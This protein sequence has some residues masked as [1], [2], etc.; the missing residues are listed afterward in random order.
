[1]E[2]IIADFKLLFEYG[3]FCDKRML[4]A[5]PRSNS[6]GLKTVK[7]PGAVFKCNATNGTNSCQD[8]VLFD[9]RGNSAYE[10]KDNQWFGVSLKSHGKSVLAC[11]HRAMYYTTASN[12]HLLEGRCRSMNKDLLS[13]GNNFKPCRSNI[14]KVLDQVPSY[15]NYGQCQSGIGIDIVEGSQT[16]FL[17][18][19]VGVKNFIGAVFQQDS[20]E[21]NPMIESEKIQAMNLS[22]FGYSV[23]HGNFLSK[24]RKDVATGGPRS[25]STGKV[26][27]ASAFGFAVCSYNIKKNEGYSYL[28]VGAPF[29]ENEATE[30]G[31]VYVYL[32]SGER[33]MQLVKKLTVNKQRANFGSA[34]VSAG[35]LDLDGINDFIVGAPYEDDF[36]GAIYIY[37]GTLKGPSN[38]Y[39]QRVSASKLDTK[40]RALGR[41]LAAGIDMDGNGYGDILAGAYLSDQAVLLRSR[42]IIK[43]ISSV[44][45]NPAKINPDNYMTDRDRFQINVTF[46]YEE[47][48]KRLKSVIVASLKLT[49]DADRTARI[50]FSNVDKNVNTRRIGLKPFDSF[51]IFTAYLV[52]DNG[53]FQS[54]PDVTIDMDFSLVQTT[55]TVQPDEVKSLD[56][57]PVLA[58]SSGSFVDH[59]LF[60]SSFIEFKR[61]CDPCIP[62]LSVVAKK[63]ITMRLGRLDHDL[64][65]KIINSAKATAFQTDFSLILPP[66]INVILIKFSKG[67]VRTCNDPVPYMG[68]NTMTLCK[69]LFDEI[70]PK[71]TEDIV[72]VLN[73]Q[74]LDANVAHKRLTLN[75]S[76]ANKEV[77]TEADNSAVIDFEIIAEADLDIQG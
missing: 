30:Q 64:S 57:R 55:P 38:T 5:A 14:G 58:S 45:T 25:N 15:L 41:S 27:L 71:T 29:H 8:E 18:G 61:D 28:L 2:D 24:T 75:V 17:F 63:N 4:V 77:G 72:I 33:N 70:K 59:Q 67:G 34:I 19:T 54:Y 35:D 22:Y 50:K 37:H 48:S 21:D 7:E 3:G 65:A 42:P 51:E 47:R 23:T 74:K 6:S 49:V 40:L 53:K 20:E 52:R 1:M 36:A 44:T 43:I 73:T 46:R 11:A 26:Q 62:D 66:G 60:D 13:S 9:K 68:G 10:N 12:Y 16:N 56:D 76:S 69:N 32:R 31:M 39:S